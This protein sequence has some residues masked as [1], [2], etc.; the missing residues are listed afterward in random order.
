MT[1]RGYSPAA[2]HGPL[3]EVFSL[4]AEHRLSS[5]G[6]WLSCSRYVESSWTK[7][8]TC[9]PS[10]GRWILNHQT[11]RE[12]LNYFHI[13]NPSSGITRLKGIFVCITLNAYCLVFQ[14]DYQCKML[15]AWMFLFHTIEPKFLFFPSFL[16][17]PLLLHILLL[18]PLLLPFNSMG[19]KHLLLVVLMTMSH[20]S[21]LLQK[22]SWLWV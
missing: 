4:I 12:V 20:I 6:L 2:L 10:I 1:T 16:P 13:A 18:L 14:C 22:C 9:I 17:S 3:I 11:I 21:T 8:R 5:W 19:V 15:S 7:D